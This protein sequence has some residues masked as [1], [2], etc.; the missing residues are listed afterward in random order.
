MA[1]WDAHIAGIFLLLLSDIHRGKELQDQ[2]GNPLR[3]K[4]KRL[5][6]STLFMITFCAIIFTITV[7]KLMQKLQ[8]QH[9]FFIHFIFYTHVSFS[10][11]LY[12]TCFSYHVFVFSLI[13]IM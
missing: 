13:Y 1:A 8:L 10:M 4:Q 2:E 11:T 12:Y 6:I 9:I 5:E 7:D 3:T